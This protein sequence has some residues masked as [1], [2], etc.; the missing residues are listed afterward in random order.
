MSRLPIRTR[1]TLAFSGVMAVLLAALGLFIYLRYES[2]LNETIEQGLRSRAAEAGAAALADGG[3]RLGRSG[4]GSLVEPD[5][6]FAQLVSASGRV[7]DASP[8][9]GT[10]PVLDPDRLAAAAAGPVFFDAPPPPG[11]EGQVRVLA[12][13]V[14]DVPGSDVIVVGASL[15]DRDEALANLATLLLI[16][17][18]VALLLASLA[19]YLGIGA[20]LRPVE[21]MR[22]R[23]AAL[24]GSDLG[25][26]LPVPAVEDEIH[27]LG[28]TLNGM[29]DRVE[30]GVRRERAF[31]DDASHELRTPLALLKTELELAGRYSDDPADLRSAI[32]SARAEVDRLIELAEALLVVARANE[33]QLPLDRGRVDVAELLAAVGERFGPRLREDDRPLWIEPGDGLAIVADRDR[34]EQALTGLVENAIRH[35]SGPIRL[36]AEPDGD[37]VAIHVEDSGPGFAEGFLPRAFERFSRADP[38]RVGAGYGLGLAIVDAIAGAHGG[39]CGAANR[40]GGGADAWIALPAAVR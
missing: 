6:S 8:H 30:A 28:E 39:R 34:A 9:V 21:D 24:S 27:R 3:P 23:A 16:G 18:P 17:G 2:Q 35:G 26:R 15:D 36:R 31:V 20:A 4:G 10:E 22:S 37:L 5:E 11:V 40:A 12:T 38:G 19:G 7:V 32:A 13:A 25:E 29:L 14:A 33:G 1:V